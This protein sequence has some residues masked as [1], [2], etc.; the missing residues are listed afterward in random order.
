[1]FKLSPDVTYYWDVVFISDTHPNN[2]TLP[3]LAKHLE[4]A[5]TVVDTRTPYFFPSLS[6]QRIS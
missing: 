5:A 3:N 1:M 2:A 4:T 6:L